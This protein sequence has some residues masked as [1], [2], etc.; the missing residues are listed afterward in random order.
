[1][2]VGDRIRFYR[3]MRGMT[4]EELATNLGVSPQAVYKYEK[5]IVTNISLPV[6]ERIASALNVSPEVIACWANEKPAIDQDDG[7]AERLDIFTKLTPDKQKIAL[8]YMRF[9]AGQQGNR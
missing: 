1:M 6:I 7:Y 2:A 4:Q 9:L 3:E 8:D 5:G